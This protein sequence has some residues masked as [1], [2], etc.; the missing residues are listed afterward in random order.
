MAD[1]PVAVGRQ[2]RRYAVAS[3]LSPLGL[4]WMQVLSAAL[5]PFPL[6]VGEDRALWLRSNP[7]IAQTAMDQFIS[8]I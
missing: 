2:G 8:Q 7:G 4:G 3:A 1:S 5:V 6:V